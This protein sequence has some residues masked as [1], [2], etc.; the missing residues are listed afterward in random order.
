[1][2]P[3]LSLSHLLPKYLNKISAVKIVRNR[4]ETGLAENLVAAADNRTMYK[5]SSSSRKVRLE[6]ERVDFFKIWVSGNSNN[7]VYSIFTN[8][9]SG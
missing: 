8:R 3:T 6:N 9:Y 4:T 2:T 5:L 7:V 1:M